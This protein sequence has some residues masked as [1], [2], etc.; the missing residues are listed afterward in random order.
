MHIDTQSMSPLELYKV[1]VG[2]IIPRPIA[3]VSTQDSAGVTNLAPYSFFSVASCHPPVLTITNVPSQNA[4]AKD[5]LANLLETK[6][7]V[8]NIVTESQADNM[9][10]SCAAYSAEVSEIDEIGIKTVTSQ[11]VKPPSIEASPV[12]Y[13]CRLRE[14]LTLSEE[15]LGGALILLD[16]IAVY[17]ADEVMKDGLIQADLLQVVGKLGGNDYCKANA[18]LTLMRPVLE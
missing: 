8:V 16:V 15:P 3:W 18:D 5:T 2:G 12:R 1:L 11:Q 4:F 7:C 10:S 17:V 6:E 14:V 13:E 9:N